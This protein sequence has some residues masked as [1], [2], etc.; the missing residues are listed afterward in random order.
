MMQ[1]VASWSNYKHNSHSSKRKD[2]RRKGCGDYK[3]LEYVGK[4]RHVFGSCYIYLAEGVIKELEITAIREQDGGKTDR[5]GSMRCYQLKGNPSATGGKGNGQNPE[6]GTVWKGD[7]RNSHSTEMGCN[8][9]KLQGRQFALL[10]KYILKVNTVQ[11]NLVQ[12]TSQY[13]TLITWC[14]RKIFKR[15]WL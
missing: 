1:V 3:L 4:S 5:Q 11:C 13:C 2:F 9:I 6:E 12:K 10:P 7:T 15:I 8:K 14:K